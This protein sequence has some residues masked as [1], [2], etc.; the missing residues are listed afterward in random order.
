MCALGLTTTAAHGIFPTYA[1]FDRN[2]TKPCPRIGLQI[3]AATMHGS[4]RA[5]KLGA[6]AVGSIV[7]SRPARN[8][9]SFGAP[10]PAPRHT[11]TLGLSGN[12]VFPAAYAA[13]GLPM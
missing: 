10:L 8:A 7:K 3:P 9:A 1:G 6:S 13:P 2:I 5:L 12:I 4:P 11:V